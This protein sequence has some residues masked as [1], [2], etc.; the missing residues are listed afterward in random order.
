MKLFFVIGFTVIATFSK[1]Q[2]VAL[3]LDKGN[4]YYRQQQY[5]MAERQ[6]KAALEKEPQNTTAQYNLSNALYQQKKFPE[7]HGVLKK[8]N[9]SID[10]VRLKEAAY[11]NDGVIYTKEKNLDGSI[12]AYKAALRL[13]PDDK[14][15]RENLQ[16]ALSE[17][18]KQQQQKQQQQKQQQKN[19]N[20]SQKAAEQK[21]KL[22]Q[23]REKQLQERLQQNGQKGNSMP[24]DW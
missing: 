18:K 8:L 3:D 5:D 14:D 20:M 7:A 12:Q 2:S 17:R 23:E 21:L 15:A 1:A 24:K 16:K 22:L 10:D 19:S 9:K 6:Y 11:Y 13:D 4:T